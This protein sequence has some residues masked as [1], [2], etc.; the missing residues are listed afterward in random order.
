MVKLGERRVDKME[1]LAGELLGMEGDGL[2]RHFGECDGS[3]E[4]VRMMWTDGKRM[5]GVG[6]Q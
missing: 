6:R 3:D 5:D 1:K 2:K 4:D